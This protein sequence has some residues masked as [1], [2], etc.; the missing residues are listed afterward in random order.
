MIQGIEI[1]R[2]VITF[3]A[4]LNPSLDRVLMD[5]ILRHRRWGSRDKLLKLVRP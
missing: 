3:L 4:F 2:V 1:E 5:V